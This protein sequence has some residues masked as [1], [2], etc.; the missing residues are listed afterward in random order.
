MSCPLDDSATELIRG[1]CSFRV[2]TLSDQHKLAVYIKI[3]RLYLEVRNATGLI[4][5]ILA[6]HSFLRDSALHFQAGE[7]G[8][9][10]TTFGRAALLIHLTEDKAT[11]LAYKLCQVRNNCNFCYQTKSQ[12]FVDADRR[13]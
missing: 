9:A 2:R 11:Q 12:D 13:D 3:V 5:E 6:N 8:L 1:S 7:S 10:Q 4:I